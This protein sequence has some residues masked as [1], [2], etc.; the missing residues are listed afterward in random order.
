MYRTIAA[1]KT[2]FSGFGLP[3]YAKGSVPDDVT[4]PYI[5]FSAAVPNRDTPGSLYLQIWDRTTSNDLIIRKADEITGD[6]GQCKNI[7]IEGGYVVIRPEN[8]LIDIQV[9][10][11]FRYAYVNL[12]VS[13]L[14]LPG[15]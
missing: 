6:I 2:Y 10:G 15:I 7:P 5:V 9:A 3:A 1:L 14:H 11:D 12:T 8:S 4:T 13:A